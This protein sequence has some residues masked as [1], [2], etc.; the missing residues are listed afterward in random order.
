MSEK[1]ETESS[2]AKSGG[3]EGLSWLKPTQ[4]RLNKLAAQDPGDDPSDIAAHARALVSLSKAMVALEDWIRSQQKEQ[5]MEED[6]RAEHARLRAELERRLAR[7]RAE[8]SAKSASAESE[9]GAGDG[10]DD[11]LGLLG[12]PGSDSP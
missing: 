12:P 3:D 4:A 6:A 2:P 10:S 11:E 5:D 8:I 7:L 9:P 1:R